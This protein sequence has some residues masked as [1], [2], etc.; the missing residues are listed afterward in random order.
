MFDNIPTSI[1]YIRAGKL[2]PFFDS[3]GGSRSSN[4]TI[5]NETGSHLLSDTPTVGEFLP[6]YVKEVARIVA[7]I[8]RRP[9]VRILLRAESGFNA[10]PTT[11]GQRPLRSE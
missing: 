9:C 11:A 4:E 7:Q 3:W 6:G 8:R 10:R 5:G 1:E 2:R